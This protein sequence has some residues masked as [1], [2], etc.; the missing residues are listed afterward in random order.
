MEPSQPPDHRCLSL[1]PDG[2]RRIPAWALQVFRQFSDSVRSESEILHLALNGFA[3]LQAPPHLLGALT[4]FAEPDAK[5]F[6]E[7]MILDAQ[8]TA[9]RA[10][11]HV[12]GG[13]AFLLS[14]ACVGLWSSMEVFVED[15]AVEWLTNVPAAWSL[16]RLEKI[17]LPLSVYRDTSPEELPRLAVKELAR[18]LAADLRTGI[19]RLTPLL[20]ELGLRPAVGARA[21]RCLHELWQVRNVIVHRKGLCDKSLLAHCPWVQWGEGSRIVIPHRLYGW[22]L[23]GVARFVERV[24]HEAGVSFGLPR[25]NCPGMD[26]IDER[27]RVE[28]EA[29]ALPDAA[30]A[31]V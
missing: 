17:K 29:T 30:P 21:T 23:C 12:E 5:D 20:S 3:A 16:P 26:E 13:T 4:P 6:L 19:G 1:K 10:R 31:E 7:R 11:Q 27:P 14:H 2:T 24:L 28:A 25:C 9:E 22:Y 18:S 8:A 15:L